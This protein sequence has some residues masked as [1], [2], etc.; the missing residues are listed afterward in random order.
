MR[1]TQSLFDPA[2][3][4]LHCFV[5]DPIAVLRGTSFERRTMATAVMLIWETLSCKLS[6]SKGQFGNKVSWI[7]GELEVKPESVHA[8][9]KPA[10]MEDIKCML[11]ELDGLNYINRKTLESFA[12]KLNHAASLLVV[13][14]PFLQQIWAALQTCTG[15]NNSIWRRQIHHALSWLK[16]A[17][18]NED[19]LLYRRFMVQD[20]LGMGKHVEIGT[21]ASPFGL[22][23]WMAV[24]GVITHYFSSA[25]TSFDLK[26]FDITKG[27]C[28]GQQVLECLAILVPIKLWVPKAQERIAIKVRSDN[29]GALTLVVKMRPH[30]SRM[31]I[32]ARE[33]ALVLLHHSFLPSVVHTPG[34]AHKIADSLS[35]LDDP[36]KSNAMEILKHPALVNAVR[37]VAPERNPAYYCTLDPAEGSHSIVVS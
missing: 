9:I 27:S 26:L 8:R 32:I 36:G 30:N 19:L 28:D 18:A 37:S 4:R 5:D 11:K 1:L 20:Y 23:G 16:A 6:F 21:D 29:I 12:G 14:R 3:F 10:I 35:R 2:F 31:A 17:F 13:L 7:G 22:G 34:I 33:L 24:D 25:V 15:P